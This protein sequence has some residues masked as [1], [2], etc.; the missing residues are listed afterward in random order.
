M[1]NKFF[2]IAIF[3]I[4]LVACN[5][6]GKKPSEKVNTAADSSKADT[7]SED[8]GK[9]ESASINGIVSGYLQ[10]KN[11]LVNDDGSGAADAGKVIMDAVDKVDTASL[12]PAQKK[13]FIDVADD[14]KENAEHCRKNGNKIE[15]QREHFDIL[16]Q[17]MYALVKSFPPSQTLYKDK[18]LMYNESKGAFWLSETKE[19]KNPY[20][21]KKMLTC[22]VIKEEIK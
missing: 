11:A 10:L 9:Q 18:C 19:I 6:S 22:G 17:D 2:G 12:S 1:K 7:Q 5:G 8:K 20:Y 13:A 21:G 15:H 16:S 3:S 14:I 4:L